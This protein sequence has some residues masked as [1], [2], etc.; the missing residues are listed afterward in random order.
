[1]KVFML[2][3]LFQVVFVNVYVNRLYIRYILYQISCKLSGSC[4][5]LLKAGPLPSDNLKQL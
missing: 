2:S 4:Q 5:F 1:M 3:F